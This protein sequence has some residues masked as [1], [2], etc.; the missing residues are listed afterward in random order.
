MPKEDIERRKKNAM[1]APLVITLNLTVKINKVDRAATS[2]PDEWVPHVINVFK[3]SK[4][5]IFQM[6]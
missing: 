3:S 5:V 6:W 1:W 2:P 4:P